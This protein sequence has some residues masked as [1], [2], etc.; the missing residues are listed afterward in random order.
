M[1]NFRLL[2][3]SELLTVLRKANK[4]RK[5]DLLVLYSRLS[6]KQTNAAVFGISRYVYYVLRNKINILDYDVIAEIIKD[7]EKNISIASENHNVNL[8]RPVICASNA[9]R[10]VN[11]LITTYS[12][13]GK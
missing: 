5:L 4:P 11:F 1:H 12:N 6:P 10:L 13:N 3:T 8:E 7:A 9:E 2:N